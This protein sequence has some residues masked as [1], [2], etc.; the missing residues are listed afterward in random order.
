MTRGAQNAK[1]VSL[2]G[3]REFKSRETEFECHMNHV[4][5]KAELS[6]RREEKLECHIHLSRT[7]V[8]PYRKEISSQRERL[9]DFWEDKSY[10]RLYPPSYLPQ[11]L[12]GGR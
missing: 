1:E 8:I 4:A 6:Y 11:L 12:E 9:Q 7:L 10:F 5:F 2:E 3:E